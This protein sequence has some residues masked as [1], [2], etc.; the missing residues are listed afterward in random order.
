MIEGDDSNVWNQHTDMNNNSR[1]YRSLGYM[2]Q[3]DINLWLVTQNIPHLWLVDCRLLD[4][5]L[6]HTSL[7]GSLI[8]RAPINLKCSASFFDVDN[9]VN[10]GFWLVDTTNT[11]FW[12]VV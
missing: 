4:K 10:T 9:K 3:K 5:F 2:T 6:K 1:M 11:N 7:D 8:V 12:L